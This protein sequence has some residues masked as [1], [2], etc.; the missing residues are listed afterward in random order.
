MRAL[1]PSADAAR[2]RLARLPR[3]SPS[4]L[5][6]TR[7][8]H[9]A[10]RRP[11]RG[12]R[13]TRRSRARRARRADGPAIVASAGTAAE[14]SANGGRPSAAIAAAAL[15]AA[16]LS[17]AALSASALSA[18]ALAAAVQSAAAPAAEAATVA[19]T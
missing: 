2:A 5:P 14:P 17:A 8:G 12:P 18:A 10:S 13:R 7:L 1:N 6:R 3:Y 16:A 9:C 4:A 15:A 19:A 11:A